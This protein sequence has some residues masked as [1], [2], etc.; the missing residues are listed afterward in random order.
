MSASVRRDIVRKLIV[1]KPVF[2]AALA[3]AMAL[4][5]APAIAGTVWTGTWRL[6]NDSGSTANDLHL[7]I[8]N[9]PGNAAYRGGRGNQA[10]IDGGGLFAEPA[11]DRWSG[12]TLDLS[13]P[14]DA[15]GS[16]LIPPGAGADL[17]VSV[18]SG[19]SSVSPTITQA[20]WTLGG[21]QVGPD[22]PLTGFTF[23]VAELAVPQPDWAEFAEGGGGETVVPLPAAGTL[24]VGAL[25]ALGIGSR[26]GR[27][28]GRRRLSA[29]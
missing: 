18:W 20:W 26:A 29:S 7:T 1:R 11:G 21:T 3:C 5:A 10:D 9:Q 6:V 19:S 24:L 4:A 13:D 23:V 12:F 14:I 22:I 28:G 25:A 8:V 27:G 15:L 16:I 2:R 17:S